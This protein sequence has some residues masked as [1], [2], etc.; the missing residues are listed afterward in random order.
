MVREVLEWVDDKMETEVYQKIE[1][2]EDSEIKIMA[3][4]FGLGAIEGLIDGFAIG[5]SMLLVL[6]GTCLLCGRHKK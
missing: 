1:E 5:G 3:K 2:G 6:Y 4:A